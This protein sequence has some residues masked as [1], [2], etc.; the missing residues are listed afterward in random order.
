[1]GVGTDL[2]NQLEKLHNNQDMA[3]AG[4]LCTSD[5]VYVGPGVR[6]QGSEAIAAYFAEATKGMSDLAVET[7]LVIEDGDVVVAEWTSRATN[8][9]PLTMPD[10]T[11]IPPTG[12]T[13]ELPVVTVAT[14]RDGKFATMRDYFDTADIARQLGLM[15][16]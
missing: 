12:K 8:T 11:E 5:A 3:G 10:G 14:V 15:P 7:S 6:V 2:W 9:G 16:S 4:S 1:M 13:L